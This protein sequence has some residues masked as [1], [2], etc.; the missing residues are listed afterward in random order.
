MVPTKEMTAKVCKYE[1]HA[2]AY[3]LCASIGSCAGTHDI[4]MVIIVVVTRYQ[5]YTDSFV[6]VKIVPSRAAATLSSL[7]ARA[8]SLSLVSPS[9]HPLRTLFAHPIL[10]LSRALFRALFR[11]L[12]HKNAPFAIEI[13]GSV[14]T[15]PG[16]G[17]T[18]DD[19]GSG[20]PIG[21]IV[22]VV[23]IVVIGCVF[24]TFQ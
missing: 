8:R 2:C 4:C 12:S 7:V 17:A 14:T 3:T 20:P 10:I 19:D 6:L 18:G 13:G 23:A 1:S 21:I 22:G 15:A 11:A 16:V 9:S 5:R 24:G